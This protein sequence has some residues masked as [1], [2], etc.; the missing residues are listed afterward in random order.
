MPRTYACSDGRHT[1]ATPQTCRQPGWLTIR[2]RYLARHMRSKTSVGFGALWLLFL[3]LARTWCAVMWASGAKLATTSA[4][5][6]ALLCPTC[7]R[8]NR[9]WRL[10]LL[11]SMVSR[12]TWHY[13]REHGAG[14]DLMVLARHAACSSPPVACDGCRHAIPAL[15][16]EMQPPHHFNLPESGQHQRFE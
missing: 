16:V 15:A 10:R 4:A 12:S 5:T 2:M 9:N 14:D 6:R 3:L 8:R 11:V 1:L 7:A 13:G